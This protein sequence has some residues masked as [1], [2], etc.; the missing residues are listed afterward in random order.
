MGYYQRAQVNTPWMVV[1]H[2]YIQ[3]V[4]LTINHLEGGNALRQ[5]S[6]NGSWHVKSSP[7]SAFVNKV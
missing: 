7:Q 6:A 3:F 4:R 5:E 2:K 1:K